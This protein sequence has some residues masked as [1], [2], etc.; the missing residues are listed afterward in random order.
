VLIRTPYNKELS[1]LLL[2]VAPDP[3]RLAQAGFAVV[4]QDCR[5]CAS[6]AGQFNPFFQ[7][8]QDGNDTIAWITAQSWSKGPVG[9]AGGSYLGAVQWLAATEGPMALQ[10]L[11]PYVTTAQYYH[12]WTY[13]GGAFQLGFCLFWA[14]VHTHL[15][16][17]DFRCIL[18]LK[19]SGG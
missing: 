19:G 16:F 3:L 6:S 17:S 9:M 11:A 18:V 1:A 10:A 14:L 8:A 7:E 12:P 13:Q 5:G 4:V 15:T 2:L